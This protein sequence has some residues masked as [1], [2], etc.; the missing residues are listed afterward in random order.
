MKEKLRSDFSGNQKMAGKDYEVYYYSDSRPIHVNPHLH[1]NYEVQLI[2]EGDVTIYI[3]DQPIVLEPD[4]MVIIPPHLRHFSKIESGTP[5]RRFI[6]W[7]TRDFFEQLAGMN[8]DF[9]YLNTIQSL[10]RYVWHLMPMQASNLQ[11]RMIFLLENTALTGFGHKAHMDLCAASLILCVSELIH[12]EL[13]PEAFVKDEVPLTQALINY[14]Q[15][16]LSEDLSLEKLADEFFISKYHI[17][18]QF[19]DEMGISLHLYVIKKRLEQAK[20]RLLAGQVMSEAVEQSGFRNY[21]SFFR[22]FQKEFGM[23]PTE[24]RKKMIPDDESR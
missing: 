10:D 15:A 21:S 20:T 1:D 4:D 23:S 18:H 6:F 5:Y 11:T 17:A 16:H 22:A 14:I 19:K 24:Y 3:K 12:E 7:V 8:E 2:L 9:G 13:N